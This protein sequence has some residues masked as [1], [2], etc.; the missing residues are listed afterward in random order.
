ML[1]F[2]LCSVDRMLWAGIFSY[3]LRLLLVSAHNLTGAA[4]VGQL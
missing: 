2:T 4:E 1:A 3:L